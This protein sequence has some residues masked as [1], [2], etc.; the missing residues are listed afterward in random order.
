ML[1]TCLSSKDYVYIYLA[2][3]PINKINLR[4]YYCYKSQLHKITKWTSIMRLVQVHSKLNEKQNLINF[5]TAFKLI[6]LFYL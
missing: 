2:I 6:K 3:V 1:I 5:S 4:D